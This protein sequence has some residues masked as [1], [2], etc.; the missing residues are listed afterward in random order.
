MQHALGGSS[1]LDSPCRGAS[2]VPDSAL[3]QRRFDDG[4]AL[5]G[6][7]G[8][9]MIITQHLFPNCQRPPHQ[10]RRLPHIL[11]IIGQKCQIVEAGGGIGM[12][13][14]ELC[15]PDGEG[16]FIKRPCL[17]YTPPWIPAM[18]PDC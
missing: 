3:P 6:R 18:R 8:I 13:G 10:P 4:K 12:V 16:A 14:A 7:L 9:G 1:T 5:A 15:F 11:F 17:R 2:Q